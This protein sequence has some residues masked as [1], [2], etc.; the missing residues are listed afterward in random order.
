MR[1]AIDGVRLPRA[2]PVALWAKTLTSVFGA[3]LLLAFSFPEWRNYGEVLVSGDD[4]VFPDNCEE[5][6]WPADN[7]G[8]T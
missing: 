8:S 6:K 1:S 2:L 3:V 5:R 4:T 7:G